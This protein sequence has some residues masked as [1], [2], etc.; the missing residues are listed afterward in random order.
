MRKSID[1]LKKQKNI[2]K[3][4]VLTAYTS[5]IS[6][7]I[8][9]YVDI[10]LVGDSLGTVIY[11][12]NNTQGVT[13]NMMMEHGKAVVR[14]SKNAFTIVDMPY[15]TYKNKREALIN[16]K[17]ILKFTKCQSIKLE[18]NFKTIEI[19]KHLVKNKI[20]V[21]SHIGVTPQNYKNFK[22]IRSVG[23]SDREKLDI[24]NLAILLE[25]AGTSMIVLECMKE[26]LAKKV[27]EEIAIPTIGIGAS[28]KCDGQVL[29]T[30][31]ILNLSSELKKPKF[32][33]EYINLE[34]YIKKAIKN[35]SVEVLNKKF[36]KNKNTY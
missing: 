7:I 26:K 20:T 25:K 24:I 10:I 13:L 11:G 17:K 32:V 29:V 18:T 31:D 5:S 36:P 9:K 19:V 33:K 27:T 30:N 2:K 16:A 28:V 12:M 15:N 34:P 8:D 4:I 1:E 35:Y 23:K 21:I 3:I 6:R 22:K 14:A